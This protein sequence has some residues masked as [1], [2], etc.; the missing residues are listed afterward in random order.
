MFGGRSGSL[1]RDGDHVKRRVDLVALPH[2]PEVEHGD[3]ELHVP[4]RGGHH[5]RELAHLRHRRSVNILQILPHSA[6]NTV[7]YLLPGKSSIVN[8]AYRRKFVSAKLRNEK[9]ARTISDW[10]YEWLESVGRCQQSSHEGMLL[11]QFMSWIKRSQ[12]MTFV[13]LYGGGSCIENIANIASI[14]RR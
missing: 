7:H 4:R 13:N 6:L 14:V 11:V 2:P 8:C 12:S 10:T 5:H 9:I 3:G 1:E